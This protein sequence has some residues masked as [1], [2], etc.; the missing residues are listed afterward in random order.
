MIPQETI[1]QIVSRVDILEIIGSFVNLKRRG[2]NYLGLCPFHNEKTPS[3]TVSPTKEIYKCFG[4]GK[5]GN[6]ITFLME[7]EKYSYVEALKWLA[8][9]Y[10]IEIEEQE[11]SPEYQAQRQAAD[12]L[13]VIN[14]FAKDY[15]L[16]KLYDSIDGESIGLSYLKERG[17][18]DDI[19]KSFELGYNPNETDGFVQEALKN[20]FN[21]ELLLKSGLVSLRH[22]KLVD[23]YRD[24]IIFPI[25]NQSGKVAGFG[26]RI[27]RKNDKAPKYLNTPE[28]E[29]Y[30]KSKIL[31]GSWQAKQAINKKDECLLVEGYTDVV[32]LH[33]AGI[34]N[35]VASSGTSL[36]HDQLR[37]IKKFTS[38]LTILYDGDAAGVAAAMRGLDLALEEGLYVHVVML[39]P[40]EDPD[41]F[42]QKNGAKFFEDYIAEN[43]KDFILFQL[44]M[45][46][47]EAGDDSNKKALAVKSI[48]STI[49]KISKAEDFTRQQDYIQKAAERLKIDEGGLHVLV[50][51]FTRESMQRQ[52]KHFSTGKKPSQE[53]P[54]NTPA[55]TDAEAE[56]LNLVQ[57]EIQHEK[58][59]VRCLI[60]FGIKPWSKDKTV[61]DYL[62]F[63][64]PILNFVTDNMLTRIVANYKVFYENGLKPG[65]KSF[66]YNED[67]AMSNAVI[68][69]IA[70]PYEVSSGWQ[71]KYEMKVPERE[72]NYLQDVE[73]TIRYIELKKLRKLIIENEDELQNCTSS[74]E[75]TLLLQTHVHLKGLEQQLTSQVGTVIM[76]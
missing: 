65:A 10:N 76:K 41:S 3:F 75:Q 38:H 27:I 35:V 67:L 31:Y 64:L 12:S 53:W 14:K 66:L 1:Q 2:A 54:E 39:P 26:A 36:T 6:T 52:Q 74:K 58:S 29:I 16:K 55:P 51:Q 15:F 42:V 25:H 59:L 17:F 48:A 30:I 23:N 37:L 46:L 21:Q 72:D 61:A 33:Q 32:S 22:D 44:E 9:K 49:S 47:Q 69:L 73:S 43:K 24:R 40:S 20:Q 4:C 8:E 34:E 13:Y 70:F 19:I 63:E 28:N 60:E 45:A 57:K 11:V 50:N 62:L 71:E 5:S 68:N 18:H 7:H 56:L